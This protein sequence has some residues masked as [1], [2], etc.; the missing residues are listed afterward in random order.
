MGNRTQILKGLLEGCILELVSKEESYGYRI[1][2][3]LSEFGFKEVNEGTVYPVLIRLHKKGLI[4]SEVKKSALGPKRKYYSITDD[5]IEFLNS[6]KDEWNNI[7]G[8]VSNVMKG[9]K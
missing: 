6:F 7:S 8:I 4:K 5:G 1:T 3:L 9:A 2:E